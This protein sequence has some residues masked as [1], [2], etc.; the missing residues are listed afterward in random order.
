M[1]E[2]SGGPTEIGEV[3][4]PDLIF[5]PP[6]KRRHSFWGENL[7]GSGGTREKK[8]RFGHPPHYLV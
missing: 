1:A 6:I 3:P 7:S 5:P 4:Q 2:I 8:F